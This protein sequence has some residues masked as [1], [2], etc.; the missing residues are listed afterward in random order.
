MIQ[1]A[2][3]SLI[4]GAVLSPLLMFQIWVVNTFAKLIYAWGWLDLSW[5]KAA[6]GS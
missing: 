4:V 3:E 1:K 2:I 5:L 6:L